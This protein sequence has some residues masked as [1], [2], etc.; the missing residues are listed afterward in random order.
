AGRRPGGLGGGAAAAGGGARLS[1]GRA[2]RAARRH[3]DAHLRGVLPGEGERGAGAAERD[4]HSPGGGNRADGDLGGVAAAQGGDEHADVP[5]ALLR[6]QGAAA[7][8]GPAAP[9]VGARRRENGWPVRARSVS[10]G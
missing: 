10:E 9:P 4:P 6:P 3:A 7:G 5:A 1:A 2:V 8:G